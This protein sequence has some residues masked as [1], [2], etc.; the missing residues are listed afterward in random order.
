M[1][2][3]RTEKAG[4]NILRTY[5]AL[6]EQWGIPFVE[7]N[8]ATC[9]GDTHVIIAGKETAP[10]LVLFHGVGD[11]SAL[12]WIYNA[13]SFVEHHRIYAIDTIGGPGKSTMNENYNQA[14]D[15]CLWIDEVLKQLSLSCVDMIGVSNGGYLVQLYAL[16]RPDR[17]KQGICIASSV[18]SV[19]SGSTMKTMMKIFFP[20]ALFPTKKNTEKL[21]RKLSGGNAQAFIGNPM[22]FE[23]FQWLMKGFNNMAM[24]YHKIEGFGE[25]QIAKIR[26]KVYFLVGEEDPFQK[27]GGKQEL[28]KYNMQVQFYPDAGHGLNHELAAEINEKVKRILTKN[29]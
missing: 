24:G 6:L 25:E 19:G 22:L 5:D 7:R 18:A 8:I 10:P 29:R 23:H 16:K 12:M 1:K 15:D 3:Y 11:D 28:L 2:K 14:F 21:L 4:R 13:H 17:V 9:Y 27:L 26:D 20:E